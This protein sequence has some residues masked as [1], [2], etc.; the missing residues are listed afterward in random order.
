MDTEKQKNRYTV[1]VKF[2]LTI[3]DRGLISLPVKLRKALG[4]RANDQL[5]AET[6]SEGIL[7]RPCVSLPIEIYDADRVQEFESAEKE[8][9]DL[10]GRKGTA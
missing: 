7:L 1:S 10:F 4:L 2:T 8:L 5:I 6:T 3:T 9:A